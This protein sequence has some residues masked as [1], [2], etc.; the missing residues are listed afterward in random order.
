LNIPT[1]GK[2]LQEQ[3][4]TSLGAASKGFNKDGDG[5][6]DCIA[7]PNIYELFGEKQGKAAATA[8]LQGVKGWADAQKENALSKE[9]LLTVYNIQADLIVNKNGACLPLFHL[10][11]SFFHRLSAS[12][13]TYSFLLLTNNFNIF[14]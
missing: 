2:N 1:V 10:P 7:F 12:Y 6:S 14:P 4:M 3:T 13:F 8:I 11:F 9:A 5:P